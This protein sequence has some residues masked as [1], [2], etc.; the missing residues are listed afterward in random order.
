MI[1]LK[2]HES[3]NSVVTVL[4]TDNVH[5]LVGAQNVGMSSITF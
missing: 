5:I 1:H 4:F 2:L 3:A